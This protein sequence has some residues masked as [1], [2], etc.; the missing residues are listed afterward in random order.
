MVCSTDSRAERDRIRRL[1]SQQE[2][3]Y[4]GN[5]GVKYNSIRGST[6]EKIRHY[7]G[8]YG[9][10]YNSIRGS[11]YEKMTN[12]LALVVA[13]TIENDAR[14]RVNNKIKLIINNTTEE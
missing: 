13:I 7:D 11:T 5:Y 4:Y 6:Y 2:R 9:V 1:A 3:H 10:K 12:A 14:K 8:N